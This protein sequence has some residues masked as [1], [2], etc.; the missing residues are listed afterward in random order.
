ME[1][2]NQLDIKIDLK[3]KKKLV[4]QNS[5]MRREERAKEEKKTVIKWQFTKPPGTKKGADLISDACFDE[6]DSLG[7]ESNLDK[8]SPKARDILKCTHLDQASSFERDFAKPIDTIKE[9]KFD[10][11]APPYVVF[12]MQMERLRDSSIQL[13]IWEADKKKLI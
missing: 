12:N 4:R 8:N 1:D 13:K 2:F 9:G 3:A 6:E 11:K 10:A 5:F 7:S